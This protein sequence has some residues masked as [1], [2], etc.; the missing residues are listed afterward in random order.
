MAC[1]EVLGGVPI[2]V[3]VKL[4]DGTNDFIVDP[5][6]QLD[7]AT[8]N[9]NTQFFQKM[10]QASVFA[11]GRTRQG[12]EATLSISLT[13]VMDLTAIAFAFGASVVTNTT[14]KKVLLSDNAG[15]DPVTKK[16]IVKPVIAGVP[17]TNA[18][19]WVTFP[20]GQIIDQSSSLSYGKDS[21]TSFQAQIYAAP[22]AV[23]P[24]ERVIFGDE[25]A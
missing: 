5:D 24:F 3:T 2:Q 20:A 6:D 1:S 21:Q 4:W 9:I 19:L 22:A 13:N 23:T 25:T 15:A 18:N 14:K 17:T 10:T 8:L 16:V 12:L 7:A 11:C